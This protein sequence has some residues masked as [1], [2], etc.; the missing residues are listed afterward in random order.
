MKR[1]KLIAIVLVAVLLLALVPAAPAAAAQGRWS[2]FVYLCGSDLESRGGAATANLV[3][4][5]KVDY[6]DGVT[7]LVQTG[8]SKKWNIRGVDAGKLQRFVVQK[9]RLKLVD[10]QP[11]ASMGD[12]KTL[13][14][15]LQYGIANYPADHYMTVFWNHGSG[16]VGGVCFDE[17]YNSDCLSLTEM[18]KALKASGVQYDVLGFDTCLMASLELANAIAPYGKYMVASEEYEPGGG[19]DYEGFLKYI[20]T[21]PN[22][23]GLDLGKK[24]CDTY[25]AKCKRS[26][27]DDMATLSVV[28]LAKIPAVVDAFD[29]MASE[30]N[31][32]TQD[33]AT[34]RT[35]T[36]A[37]RS[38]ESYG[39]KSAREGYSNMVDLGDLVTKAEAVLSK[40]GMDVLNALFSSV[41]YNVKG[42][43][44]INANG[45]SVFY[46]LGDI[47]KNYLAVYFTDAATSQNYR[48]Y[49][50][51]VADYK[52]DIAVDS[53]GDA[54]SYTSGTPGSTG[55]DSWMDMLMNLL[56]DS[57]GSS[58]TSGYDQPLQEVTPGQSTQP[59]PF[60][61]L[62]GDSS[63]GSWMD[64]LSG[65]LG[66]DSSSSNS[67]YGD[68]GSTLTPPTDDGSNALGGGSWMDLL[69]GLLGDG[70]SSGGYGD[71]SL[72]DITGTVEGGGSQGSVDS[73]NSLGS[74]GGFS[75]IAEDQQHDYGTAD[76]LQEEDYDVSFENYITEDGTY[77]LIF[78]DGLDSVES[79]NFVLSYL[80]YDYN[81]YM[82]LG[83]DNDLDADWKNG[84]FYDNFR[85]VWPTI[86]GVWCAP[87]L[88]A[89]EETYNLY[90]IPVLLNGERAFLRAVY[91]FDDDPE[92]DG[93]FEVLGAW[94]GLAESTSMSGRNIRKLV[95]GD[96]VTFLFDSINWDTQETTTYQLE[97]ITIQGEPVME[98]SQLADGDY[99]YYY[100]VTD[101]FG[102][103]YYSEPILMT[104]DQGDIT[105]STM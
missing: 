59:D 63:G 1:T 48:H 66:E 49:V 43:S 54:S 14:A 18:S 61:S 97:T 69:A 80:D 28:D 33:I 94:N 46:P 79:V 81:E 39:G 22:A 44:R 103:T 53:W 52:G 40:T 29:R 56:G 31:G 23:G 19:W 93:S 36:S 83:Q 26:R 51:T 68:S 99:E 73:Q 87:L 7:V 15:F 77:A 104:Y 34:F 62:G 27:T 88:I 45:L 12:A 75:W 6:P 70:S 35:L 37:V 2:V 65:L 30:M 89:E 21:N 50:Q 86:D 41:S 101:L 91:W 58:G 96:E 25:M 17:L 71:Y 55:G 98:E 95:K 64:L 32:T 10:E 60:G 100:I 92:V 16:S 82:A 85:G 76:M 11:R 74:T 84:F 47:S 24:I 57:S 9:G 67:G 78:K 20:A 90:T 8:G 4:A 13:T 38:A 5:M 3:E 72:E 102:N 105:L 42:R